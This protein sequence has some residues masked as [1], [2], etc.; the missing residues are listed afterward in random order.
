MYIVDNIADI[1]QFIDEKNLPIVFE[2]IR[3]C[4]FVSKKYVHAHNNNNNFGT[5]ILEKSGILFINL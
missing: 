3:V 2:Y 1:G 4:V 5:A